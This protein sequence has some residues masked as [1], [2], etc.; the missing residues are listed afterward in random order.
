[1]KTLD[2]LRTEA[3]EEL[4]VEEAQLRSQGVLNQFDAND[5]GVSGYETQD[6]F[7]IEQDISGILE[8][9]RI[10]REDRRDG[11][12]KAE[13]GTRKFATVPMAV[14]LEYQLQ[15]GVDIMDGEVSL[16][17]WEMAKFRM[18]IQK[19]HPELMVREAGKT[20]FHT[21]S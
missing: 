21:A 6:N 20:R 9:V 8:D 11:L 3:L 10:E 2:E 15:K 19:T 16:D 4:A 13:K 17:K 5:F 7:S 12:Y 14:L 18:W 1:M